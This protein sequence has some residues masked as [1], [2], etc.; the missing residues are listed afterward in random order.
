VYYQDGGDTETKVEEPVVS[1][2]GVK[3]LLS[4]VKRLGERGKTV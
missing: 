4:R 2:P 3:D 1:V